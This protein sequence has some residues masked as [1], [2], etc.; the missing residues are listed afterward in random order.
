[1]VVVEEEEESLSLMLFWFIDQGCDFNEVIL[2]FINVM[3]LEFPFF[4]HHVISISFFF[5]KNQRVYMSA[6]SSNP[7]SVSQ[8]GLEPKVEEGI[9]KHKKEHRNEGEKQPTVVLSSFRK[10]K[11][12][13]LGAFSSSSLL[14]R[15]STVGSG[16]D[17][18]MDVFGEIPSSPSSASTTASEGSPPGGVPVPVSSSSYV[19][20]GSQP[21][22][23][24]SSGAGVETA[25][26][27]SL[28]ANGESKK[29][30]GKG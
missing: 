30:S 7:E 21:G 22:A 16:T 20:S 17:P 2:R 1:M 12:S 23:G 28:P 10:L 6:S 26:P 3:S 9:K 27:S 24:V 8:P 25:P 15:R 18:K 19:S 13:F 4:H 29:T 5:L 14:S 11:Q